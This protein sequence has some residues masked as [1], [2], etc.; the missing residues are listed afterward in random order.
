MGGNK[1]VSSHKQ[2]VAGMWPRGACPLV[3][4]SGSD[5]WH[6]VAPVPGRC[7]PRNPGLL[8]GS[9]CRSFPDLLMQP[10][11][12]GRGKERLSAWGFCT[13]TELGT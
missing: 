6:M 10:L 8:A 7:C 3:P 9:T 2:Q 13:L 5:M 11:S 1:H 12:P 4:R